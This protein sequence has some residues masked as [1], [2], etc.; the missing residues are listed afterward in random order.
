MQGAGVLPGNSEYRKMDETSD[1]AAEKI[2]QS[3][4]TKN[5]YAC[6]EPKQGRKQSGSGFDA[7]HSSVGKIFKYM[8]MVKKTVAYDIGCSQW[9][10]D[11][12]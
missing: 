3:G 6:Q 9:N 2:Q 12:R 7:I 11:F 8:A 10:N 1:A 4:G 5:F